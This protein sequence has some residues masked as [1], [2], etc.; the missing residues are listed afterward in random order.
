MVQEIKGPYTVLR[1]KF[2]KT[3]SL[4]YISH[5]DLVRTMH[6]VLIRTRLPVWYSE[7]FNPKPKM[8]FSPPLS[9]GV[10]SLSEFLDVRI[11]KTVD[12]ESVIKL[13]NENLTDE[14]CVLDAYYPT[15]KL[16]DIAWYSY[17]ITLKS[18]SASAD[19]AERLNKFVK[20]DSVIVEKKSKNGIKELDIKPL[21][22][23]FDAGFK[24]GL[25]HVNATLSADPSALLN[26]ELLIKCLDK[27]CAIFKGDSPLSE[28]YSIIRE[29]A[30]TADMNAYK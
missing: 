24:D 17:K 16:S 13:F 28:Y 1:L 2:T 21:I 19:L 26:P 10:Q 7:G 20:R 15:S 25:I 5:L 6:K 18:D 30:Y 12:T 29:A 14:L 22:H 27:E 8:V 3:G 9:I 4:Q 23:S 11:T